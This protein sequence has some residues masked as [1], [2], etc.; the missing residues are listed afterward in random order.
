MSIEPDC[1]F[2]HLRGI[3]EYGEEEDATPADREHAI[4][5]TAEWLDLNS[6]R[7]AIPATEWGRELLGALRHVLGMAQL[8]ADAQARTQPDPNCPN[9]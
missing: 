1:E 8:Y 4:N 6:A 5:V 7:F 3:H 9:A 2:L